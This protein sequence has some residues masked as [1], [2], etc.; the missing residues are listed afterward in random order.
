MIFLKLSNVIGLF[1]SYK[2]SS[3]CVGLLKN[4]L[5]TKDNLASKCLVVVDRENSCV[6]SFSSAK[7][8]FHLFSSC[9]FSFI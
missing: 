9:S 5:L 6:F 3:F 7:M 4:K 1:Y 2:G 8:C